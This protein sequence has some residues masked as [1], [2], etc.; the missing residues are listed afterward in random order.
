[1]M[2]I[3]RY[4][5]DCGGERPFEQPHDLPGECPDS[6]DGECPE[7]SCTVCGAAV[8]ID[9]TILPSAPAIA[10]SVRRVA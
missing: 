10:A 5:G 6:P 4:C 7:W 9:V 3:V 8:L 2:Q 1:M